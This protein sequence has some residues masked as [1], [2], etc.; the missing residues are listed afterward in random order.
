[1]VIRMAARMGGIK[2]SV[3]LGIVQKAAELRA[4][5]VDVLSF[6]AGEPD[7]PTPPHIVEA[8]KAALDSGRTRYTPVPGIAEL[9]N[10][11]AQKS[12]E[13][14]GVDASE[15]NVV[16]SVGA[17]HALYQ[18]FQAVLNPGDEVVIPAP[19]WVSYPDQVRL[20]GAEPVIVPT[21]ADNAYCLTPK[22]LEMA[23]SERTK[24]VILNSPNNP[25]GAVYPQELID[26]LTRMT[27]R[28]GAFVVADEIYRD[29]VY[30]GEHVS[31]LS[32]VDGEHRD[33]VFVIDGV[34][35]TYSMTG[36]RIGWGIGEPGLIKSIVKIQG[37][38]TSNATT[39]AQYGALEAIKG[40]LTF[41]NE[42]KS[43]YVRRRDAM[44]SGLKKIPGIVCGRPHGAFY[45]LAD[46]TEV[47]SRMGPSV[48]DVALAALLI[49]RA[50]VAVVPGSAFGAAGHLR[51]SYATSLENIEE[52]MERLTHAFE[53]L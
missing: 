38:S 9:R 36:W 16:V 17:K 10:A 32:L 41:L 27:V 11:V 45:V 37:Q 47:L 53:K 3:T 35:K 43:Q 49:D 8:A 52:G 50:R 42:W 25:T 33:K 13:L 18:F 30:E 31:P 15:A 14:R 29:L 26:E 48:D 24:A 21:S 1:M 28:K 2:P 51:L 44:V 46:V 6:S 7:F 23:M 5:G 34:S 4:K 19:Y 22:E 40:P 39:F 12:A 20:A